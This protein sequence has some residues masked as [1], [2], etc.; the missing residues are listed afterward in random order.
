MTR[1]IYIN[2]GIFIIVNLINLI[3]FLFSL[4]NL[5]LVTFLAVPADV[6]ELIYRPWTIITYMFLHQDFFHILFNMLWFFWFAKI[7][8][9]YLD[10]KRLLATYVLGGI[11]GAVFFIA[12]FNFFPVFKPYINQSVAM[13]ASASVIA[14]VTAISF[15]VPNLTLNL[16][17]IGPVKLK[18]IAIATIAIDILSISAGNP[19]GHIAHLGGAFWGFLFITQYKKGTDFSKWFIKLYDAITGLF[20]YKPRIKVKHKKPVSD[21]DYNYQKVKDQ[22]HINLILDK[23][24]KNGYS[25]LTKEEKEILFKAS[26]K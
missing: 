7:F 9:D 22:E 18:W 3:C 24:S 20:S 19:G 4:P 16:L 12:A 26:N 17:F 1:L 13:G 5:K 10:A 11:A 25:A 14:V 2:A 23:I 21:M 8:L 15:Y 6:N